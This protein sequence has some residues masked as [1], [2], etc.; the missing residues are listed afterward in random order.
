MAIYHLEDTETTF[1]QDQQ[2]DLFGQ[3]NEHRKDPQ[4]S[5]PESVD[6]PKEKFASGFMARALF[7]ILMIMDLGWL[8]FSLASVLIALSFHL[9]LL[10]RSKTTMRWMAKS[11]LSVRRAT[12]C[13]IALTFALFCPGFGITVACAYFLMFDRSGIDECIPASLKSQFQ[14]FFKFL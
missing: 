4:E 7:F 5:A 6:T 13:F 11:F 14:E 10:G 3:P 12:V 8:I 2:L 1:H 9:C